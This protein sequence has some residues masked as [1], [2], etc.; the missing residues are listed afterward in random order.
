[1]SMTVQQMSDVSI[2]DADDLLKIPPKTDPG[3]YLR[4]R[5]LIKYIRNE[6]AKLFDLA[7]KDYT[8]WKRQGYITYTIHPQYMVLKSCTIVIDH[9]KIISRELNPMID[10]D[11]L[12]K[13]IYVPA[14]L[15]V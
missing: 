13:G 1:M 12:R 4:N 14:R 7:K 3:T 8:N 15:T 9:G 2:S 11:Y 10:E 5:D 6:E